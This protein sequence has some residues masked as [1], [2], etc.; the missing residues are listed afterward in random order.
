MDKFKISVITP[1]YN[2]ANYIRQ[3][4]ESVLIQKSS[5]YDIEHIVIDGGSTDTTIEILK[6][7]PYIRWISSK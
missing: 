6:E 4:I 1:S 3:T 2:Q 5:K 7:Y